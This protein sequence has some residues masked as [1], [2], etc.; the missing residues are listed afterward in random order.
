V[1]TLVVPY[2][3]NLESISS[4]D[5][6][7]LFAEIFH[8]VNAILRNRC[9]SKS[10]GKPADSRQETQTADSRQRSGFFKDSGRIIKYEGEEDTV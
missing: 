1:T 4:I 10:A 8:R 6:A 2:R 7:E 9:P 3:R 5:I